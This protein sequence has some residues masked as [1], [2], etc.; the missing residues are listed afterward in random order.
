MMTWRLNDTPNCQLV[1]FVGQELI[2]T[3]ANVQWLPPPTCM[4]I[5]A[6]PFH[7]TISWPR[8]MDVGITGICR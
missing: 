8:I 3:C 1:M 2:R 5:R 7:Q 4:L 6:E